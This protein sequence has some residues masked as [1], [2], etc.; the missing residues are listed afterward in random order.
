V[1]LLWIYEKSQ[2][3][4]LNR[5]HPILRLRPGLPEH[6]TC[7]YIR[8]GTTAWFAVLNVLVGTSS[9]AVWSRTA[10]RLDIHLG[11]DN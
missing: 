4:A 2:I 6:Q 11:L 10:K 9:G 5:S 3:Q 1:L 7:D 8:H